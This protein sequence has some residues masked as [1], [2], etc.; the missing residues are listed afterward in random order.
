MATQTCGKT[1]V[2]Y[3]SQCS[4]SCC[5][6]PVYGCKWTVSCPDG[7]GGTTTTSGTGLI[8]TPP[9]FPV[10]TIVGDLE[11]CVRMVSKVMKQK[12]I[13]PRELQGTRIR[14]RTVHGTPAEIAAALGL[15]L[16]AKRKP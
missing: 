15:R 4:Y 2:N 10:V 16:A 8:S 12:F 6:L 1:T 3:E 13:V 14:K 7:K 9:R 5:C 11:T